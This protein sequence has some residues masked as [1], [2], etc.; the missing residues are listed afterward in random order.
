M[1]VH[2]NR[3]TLTLNFRRRPAMKLELEDVFK[4]ST[5]YLEVLSKYCVR[6]LHMQQILRWYDPKLRA[7]ELKDREDNWILGGAGPV[8]QN[9][10]HFVFVRNGIRVFFDAYQ[11][12]SYAE[13]RYD[14]FVPVSALSS[15]MEESIAKLLV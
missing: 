4:S 12:G 2:P 10:E 5:N 14:V 13:G 1:A 3:N 8:H 15:V 6:D 7:E 9:Y 11:V